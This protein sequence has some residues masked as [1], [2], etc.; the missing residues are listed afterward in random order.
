M[1]KLIYT[2]I[3]WLVSQSLR[4]GTD[5]GDD[6]LSHPTI[7]AMDPDELADLP[8]ASMRKPKSR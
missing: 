6:P 4:P 5:W 2:L 7:R 3:K 8:F 1:L